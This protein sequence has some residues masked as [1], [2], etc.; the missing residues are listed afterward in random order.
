MKRIS[1]NDSIYQLTSEHPEILDIMIELGFSDIGKPGM[2][3]TMGRVMTLK[4]GAKMKQID[5]AHIKAVFLAE[6]F[7]IE[8][9]A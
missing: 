7:E 5:L 9:E 6:G 4:K 8:E 3:N 2:L 1:L